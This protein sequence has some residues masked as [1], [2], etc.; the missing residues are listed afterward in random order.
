[1]TTFANTL[2]WDR[3]IN[4]TGAIALL[5]GMIIGAAMIVLQSI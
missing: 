3:A 5:G 4:F 1:M 2:I